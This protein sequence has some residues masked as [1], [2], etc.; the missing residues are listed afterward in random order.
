MTRLFVLISLVALV[1]FASAE[2]VCVGEDTM[3]CAI[4]EPDERFSWFGVAAYDANTGTF[5]AAGAGEGSGFFADTLTANVVA[6][7]PTS[8]QWVVVVLG[9]NDYGRDGDYDDVGVFAGTW[10]DLGPGVGE[11]FHTPLP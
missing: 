4:V 10:N 2:T 9:M 3:A 6:Y 7:N 8:G 5:A 1:P 11:G